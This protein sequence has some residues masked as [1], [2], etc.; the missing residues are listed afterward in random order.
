M[1]ARVNILT[2]AEPMNRNEK[3]K[4]IER[5][6]KK[7]KEQFNKKYNEL[8]LAFCDDA[9]TQ[10]NTVIMELLQAER[11]LSEYRLYLSGLKYQLP[12]NKK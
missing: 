11:K 6:Y 1:R 2:G 10:Y 3:I 7:A 12:E 8:C 9:E 4:L 5:K